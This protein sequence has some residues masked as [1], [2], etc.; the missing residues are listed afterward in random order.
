MNNHERLKE[1][2]SLE[3]RREIYIIIYAWKQTEGIRTNLLVLKVSQQRRNTVI[4]SAIIPWN[5]SKR[6]KEKHGVQQE[7]WKDYSVYYQSK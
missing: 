1:L 4:K 2:C 7:R 5:I 3:W 6:Y